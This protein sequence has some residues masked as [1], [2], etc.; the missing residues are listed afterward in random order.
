M[1]VVCDI[2]RGVVEYVTEDRTKE[3]LHR[4]FD[5]RTREQLQAIEAIAMDMWEPYV[6]ATREAVPLAHDKLVFDRFHIMQHM[7]GAVD[8]VRKAEHRALSKAGD[9]SLTGTKYLWLMNHENLTDMRQTQLDSLPVR[10][11]QTGRAW[12]LKETLRD[13]W[14]HGTPAEAREF[15]GDWYSWAIRSRLEPVK[16]VARMITRRLDNVVSYCRHWITNAVSEGLNSKIMSL[17]RRAGGYGNRE[18]FK[19]AIYFHCGGLDLYPR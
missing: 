5:S 7:T 6:P 19:T 12:A 14:H 10:V 11:L 3:S 17:K 9:D 18:S 4:F 8:A 2:D 15:F 16:A 13:L 1:T